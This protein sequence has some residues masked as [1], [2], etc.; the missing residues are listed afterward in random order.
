LRIQPADLVRTSYGWLLVA[1]L[2][3]KKDELEP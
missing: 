2:V 3:A 1:K